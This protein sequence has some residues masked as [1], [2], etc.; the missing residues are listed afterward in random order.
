[1]ERRLGEGNTLGAEVRC[2][3]GEQAHRWVGSLKPLQDFYNACRVLWTC[4]RFAFCACIAH[5]I[6]PN[7][8]SF[9][10]I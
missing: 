10:S 3:G 1:M 4:F 9:A 7:R 2:G 5:V 8:W 6:L